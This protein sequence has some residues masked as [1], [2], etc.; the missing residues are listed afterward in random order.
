MNSLAYYQRSMNLSPNAA[1]PGS[2]VY[3]IFKFIIY[4]LIII[5]NDHKS[6][7]IKLRTLLFHMLKLY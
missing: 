5:I 3:R 4:V 1:S 6:A 2:V 7:A